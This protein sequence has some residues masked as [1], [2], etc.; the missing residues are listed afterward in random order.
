MY[1]IYI[2][3]CLLLFI[4]LKYYISTNINIISAFAPEKINKYRIRSSVYVFQFEVKI[5]IVCTYLAVKHI[6]QWDL[7]VKVP[8][9]YPRNV[10]LYENVFLQNSSLLV[11]E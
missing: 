7:R 4:N 8:R 2:Y 5:S 3:T 11:P 10:L 6:G 1:Y 9:P